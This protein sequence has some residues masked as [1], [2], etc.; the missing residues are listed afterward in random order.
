MTETMETFV[1]LTFKRRGIRRL[2]S[3]NGAVHDAVFI[4]ALGRGFYWQRL[5]NTGV[6]KSG[7]QIAQAEGLHHTTV[8][9]LIRLTLLAPDIIEQFMVGRQPRRFTF[10]SFRETPLPVLWPPQRAL[11][12][13]YDGEK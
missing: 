11:I 5:L 6:V 13:V 10:T 4:E 1:P 9:E 3:T 12:A 7:A 2:A 8:N